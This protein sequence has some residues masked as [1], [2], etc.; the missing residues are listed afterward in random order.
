M[1]LL[2]RY[3]LTLIVLGSAVV[4]MPIAFHHAWRWVLVPVWTAAFASGVMA[5]W[6]EASSL[7]AARRISALAVAAFLINAAGCFL[8]LHIRRDF[9]F[10]A[11]IVCWLPFF[12]GMLAGLLPRYK[13]RFPEPFD[14][15]GHYAAYRAEIEALHRAYQQALVD[16][17]G[18]HADYVHTAY[19]EAQAPEIV[20]AHYDEKTPDELARATFNHFYRSKDANNPA[21]FARHMVTDKP[22]PP[23]YP[24]N[25]WLQK[26]GQTPAQQVVRAYGYVFGVLTLYSI[27]FSNYVIS[28]NWVRGC[29]AW[30]IFFSL[31]MTLWLLHSAAP[32]RGNIHF[33]TPLAPKSYWQIL[34]VLPMLAGMS[35]ML[36]LHGIA[37]LGNAVTGQMQ[38]RIYPYHLTTHMP[39]GRYRLICGPYIM[40]VKTALIGGG[41]VICVTQKVFRSSP[42]RGQVKVTGKASWFGMHVDAYEILGKEP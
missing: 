1:S 15:K 40:H 8:L 9:S 38:E 34:W 3:V 10:W 32:G 7:T 22:L 17:Y 11:Q 36:S 37:V 28:E 14:E 25:S 31:V 33:A 27:L 13:R 19:A 24:Y 5:I 4:Y 23:D 2:I 39:P 21:V 30:S 16:Q 41:G 12:I 29:I 6:H 35:W 20:R 42:R 26:I 18:F